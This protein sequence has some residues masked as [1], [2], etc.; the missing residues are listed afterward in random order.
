MCFK[1]IFCV[2][3]TCGGQNLCKEKDDITRNYQLDSS[4]LNEKPVFP[5]YY[6]RKWLKETGQVN[7]IVILQ[8]L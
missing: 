1:L 2:T 7:H 3:G 8:M 6:S 5:E 4:D